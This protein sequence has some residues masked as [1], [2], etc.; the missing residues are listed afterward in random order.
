[1]PQGGAPVEALYEQA[2][3]MPFAPE[4]LAFCEHCATVLQKSPQA[5][6]HP[7]IMALG[8]WLRK[9]HLHQMMQDFRTHHQGETHVGRGLIFHI[10]P[11]NVDSMFI[12]S[13]IIGL[14]AGNTNVVRI[15]SKTSPQ[16]LALLGLFAETLEAHPCVKA[17]VWVVQYDHNDDITAHFSNLC[18]GRV[19]WGGNETVKRIRRIPLNPHAVELAF[20]G[21]FSLAALDAAAW[22][23]AANPQQVVAAFYNDAFTFNQQGCSSPKL[24]YWLGTPQDVAN[25]RAKFWP[26]LR[27]YAETRTETNPSSVMERAI[28]THALAIE[29]SC[30]GLKTSH[31]AQEAPYF[32][33]IEVAKLSA[34]NRAAHTGNML[35]LEHHANSL[36]PLMQWL[37]D[38]DQTITSFGIPAEAW[39]QALTQCPPRGL[40]RIVRLGTALNFAE[41]WDGFELIASLSRNITL[42]L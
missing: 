38:D 22:N 14:L 26:A 10:A 30:A 33:R 19:I 42:D 6:M 13:L 25:A 20:S 27:E 21:K 18:Q 34:V 36:Q 7:E 28:A 1:M 8:F 17:R 23:T 9:A 31:D 2:P 37:S 35:F 40:C 15:S 39:Q 5:R 4:V 24:I 32:Q 16:S 12:Y 11:S 29:A 3:W 41:H